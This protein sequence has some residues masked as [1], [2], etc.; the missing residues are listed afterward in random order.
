MGE[1]IAAFLEK[2]EEIDIVAIVQGLFAWALI[3]YLVFWVW[4]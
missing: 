2:L 4:W 3:I 1:L